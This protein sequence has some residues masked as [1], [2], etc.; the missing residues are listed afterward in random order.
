MSAS[1][2]AP[3]TIEVGYVARAHGIRGEIC[4]VHHDPASTLLTE[5]DQVWIDGVRHE[6]LSARPTKDGVLLRLGGVPDRTQAERLR[7]RTVHAARDDLDL[8]EGEVLLA[9]LVGCAVRLPD[10]APWGTVVAIDVG[11]QD[12]LVIRDGDIE[13]LVPFVP[14]LV[15]DVDLEARVVVVDPPPDYPEDPVRR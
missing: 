10:G 1:P 4:A 14:A 8:G 12:R 2:D 5:V 3:A 9:D 7:G 6:V 11:P 15:P 13:R